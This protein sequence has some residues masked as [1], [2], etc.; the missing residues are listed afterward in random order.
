MITDKSSTVSTVI[1]DP[2]EFV[3]LVSTMHKLA[4]PPADGPLDAP[5]K[6]AMLR[7]GDIMLKRPAFITNVQADN[8]TQRLTVSFVFVKDDK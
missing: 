2:A 6:P 7:I 5:P 8:S 1:E 3:S 4:C